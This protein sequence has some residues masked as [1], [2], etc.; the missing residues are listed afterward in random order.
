MHAYVTSRTRVR[1]SWLGRMFLDDC[2]A[3]TEVYFC[4][5]GLWDGMAVV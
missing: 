1:S 4:P 5:V 3:H 2:T